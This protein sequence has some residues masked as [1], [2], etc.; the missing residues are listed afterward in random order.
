MEKPNGSG[1][2]PNRKREICV[3]IGGECCTYIPN[4][5]APDGTIT[6]ALQGLTAL[7]NELKK[8]QE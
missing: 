8:I 7:A 4:N 2:N 6:K 3:L 5:I 1:H